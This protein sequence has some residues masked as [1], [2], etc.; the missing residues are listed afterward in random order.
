MYKKI[1]IFS[2]SDNRGYFEK[3]TDNNKKKFSQFFISYSKKKYLEVFI[4]IKKKTS[5]IE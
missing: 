1:K 3:I 2:S 4:F 5:Q